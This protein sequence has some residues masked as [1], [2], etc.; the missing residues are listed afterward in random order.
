MAM[1]VLLRDAKDML[2]QTADFVRELVYADDT[3]IVATNPEQADDYMKTIAQAGAN[4]GLKYN[5]KKLEV[6]PIRCEAR[7]LKP[8]GAIVEQKASIVYLGCILAADG[9]IEA[10]LG[11]RIGLAKAEFDKL[12]RV[13]SHATISTQ[14][15]LRIFDACVLS[16]LLYSLHTAWL[17]TADLAR[18]DAFQARCLR[19][20]LRIPHSYYSRI[21]NATVLE[22]A[23]R[24]KLSC[25]LLQRQLALFADITR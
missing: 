13:W 21:S 1:T 20:I 15:K 11:R 7:I 9:G 2:G 3:L 25:L 16:K 23:S 14:R 12:D 4:Y 5:W 17:K 10:E 8:D 19:R 6:L 22:R 24:N 18:L